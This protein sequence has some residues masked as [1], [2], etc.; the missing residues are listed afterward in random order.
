MNVVIYL[1]QFDVILVYIAVIQGVLVF[2]DIYF[3]F[4]RIVVLFIIRFH[5]LF[6]NI[7]ISILF[8]EFA[9]FFS[10]SFSFV[11]FFSV[12]IAFIPIPSKSMRINKA[13][14][15]VFMI[16]YVI[17]QHFYFFRQFD[18]FFHGNFIF[19]NILPYVASGDFGELVKQFDKILYTVDAFDA[20]LTLHTDTKPIHVRNQTL[21]TVDV[22]QQNQLFNQMG[23]EQV[24]RLVELEQAVQSQIVAGEQGD[25]TAANECLS[26]LRMLLL[27]SQLPG[28]LFVGVLCD[29]D[30]FVER[31]DFPSFLLQCLEFG[32]LLL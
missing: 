12:T 22:F 20:L 18:F 19:L 14:P 26:P 7:F 28:E 23:Y 25:V 24:L 13:K 30:L 31:F 5:V 21:L 4:D 11:S 16:F 9:N 3:R 17:L 8:F 10:F 32:F 2:V 29:S 15:I 6:Y 27:L 1:V